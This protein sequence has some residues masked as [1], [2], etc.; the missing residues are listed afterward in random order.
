MFRGYRLRRVRRRF[1]DSC[2]NL[3][4]ARS[5]WEQ[6]AGWRR[7]IIDL[8][9][10]VP[11]LSLHEG[12]AGLLEAIESL[13]ARAASEPLSIAVLRDYHRR[14]LGTAD[15]RAGVWRT[16]SV[17]VVGHTQPRPA[18]RAIAGLVKDLD[19]WL[20]R[21]QSALDAARPVN[22]D[23]L[24]EA[25][26]EVYRRLGD[27]HPFADA[28]GRVARLGMNHLLRRYGGPYVILPPLGS[29]APLV[30][31]LKEADAGRPETL[32]ALLRGNSVS[33]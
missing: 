30:E 15:P 7:W 14:I 2:R 1:L 20:A 19:G 16:A 8:L 21:T 3:A 24:F 18:P 26:A 10:P 12:G 23:A 31:A 22:P 27:I 33:V 28:N 4:D 17:T 6:G 9:L 32:R 11:A 29:S 13:E 5:Y 25:A